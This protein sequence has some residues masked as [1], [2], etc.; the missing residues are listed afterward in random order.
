MN[1]ITKGTYDTNKIIMNQ[2]KKYGMKT[3]VMELPYD[4]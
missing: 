1:N 3:Q 2:E 4:M